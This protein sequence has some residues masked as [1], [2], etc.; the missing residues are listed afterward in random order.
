[1]RIYTQFIRR[2]E[3]KVMQSNTKALQDIQ[4]SRDGTMRDFSVDRNKKTLTI[5][6]LWW[7]SI[8]GIISSVQ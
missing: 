6:W 4:L 3:I 1:M 7:I 8:I 5:S 2:I